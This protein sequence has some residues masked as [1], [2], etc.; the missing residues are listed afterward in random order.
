[1]STST[2]LI[3]IVVLEYYAPVVGR[4]HLYLR[5]YFNEDG[6]T[7]YDEII[8]NNVVIYKFQDKLLYSREELLG[9]MMS[10][11][12]FIE[13]DTVLIDSVLGAIDPAIIIQNSFPAKIGFIIHENHFVEGEIDEEHILWHNHY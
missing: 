9:Y 8:D 4:A 13:N 5:R 10:F 3:H 2:R 6:T 11:L 1:M 12:N 7:A